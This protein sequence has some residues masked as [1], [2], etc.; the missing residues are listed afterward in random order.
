MKTKLNKE[1]RDRKKKIYNSLTERIEKSMKECYESKTEDHDV[2]DL[3]LYHT[4]TPS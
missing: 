1:I 3:I 4:F 2:Y